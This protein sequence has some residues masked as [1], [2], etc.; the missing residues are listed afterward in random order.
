MASTYNTNGTVPR[1]I[2]ISGGTIKATGPNGSASVLK[3]YPSLGNTLRLSQKY[4]R[5][6]LHVGGWVVCARV[7][8]CVRVCVRARVCVVCV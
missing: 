2:S 3:E 4:L 5:Y 6:F 8:V 7:R 1:K